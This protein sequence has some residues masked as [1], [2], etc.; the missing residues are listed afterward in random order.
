MAK[1]VATGVDVHE[2]GYFGRMGPWPNTLFA[3]ALAWLSL[4]GLMAWWRRK[5]ART[6]GTPAAA[7][8]PWPS[9][10][11]AIAFGMFLALPLLGLSAALLWLGERG[12]DRL[13]RRQAV[14]H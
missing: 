8:H 11:R 12:W 4:T 14:V 10:L 5:P 1:V 9:W 6:L 2:G 13:T 7:K 3:A